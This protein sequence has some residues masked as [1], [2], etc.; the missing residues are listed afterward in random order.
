MIINVGLDTMSEL[1]EAIA[2]II[3]YCCENREPISHPLDQMPDG[4]LE[5]SISSLDSG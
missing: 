3:M 5:V 2:I 1:V 4:E